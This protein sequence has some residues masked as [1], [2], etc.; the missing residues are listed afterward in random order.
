MFE[1]WDW[2]SFFVGVGV[3]LGILIIG[4]VIND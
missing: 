4:I 1:T 3:G 2:I